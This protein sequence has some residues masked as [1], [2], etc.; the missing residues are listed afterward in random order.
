[1]QFAKL[2]RISCC[3]FACMLMICGDYSSD[4]FPSAIMNG[5]IDFCFVLVYSEYF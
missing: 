4:L 1:M 3:T 5:M 2:L